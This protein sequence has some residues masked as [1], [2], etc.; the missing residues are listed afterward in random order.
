MRPLKAELDALQAVLMTPLG[1]FLTDREAAEHKDPEGLA[2]KRMFTKAIEAVDEVRG[3][4]TSWVVVLRFGTMP[5]SV[6]YQSFG[7]WSTKSQADKAAE[8][9]LRATEATAYAVV[10]QRTEDGWRALLGAVD[11]PPAESSS[12]A[13]VKKDA[14]ALKKGWKPRT[15]SRDQ[16]ERRDNGSQA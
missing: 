13:E 11:A 16:F 5:S 10:P 7:P 2:Q 14:A 9:I 15:E 1:D 6:T 12:W 8:V 3:S 4:R